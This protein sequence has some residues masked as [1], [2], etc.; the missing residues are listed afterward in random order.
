MII[1]DLTKTE[2]QAAIDAGR[3]TDTSS[4]RSFYCPPGAPHASF[5][6]FRFRRHG[7]AA[8]GRRG[9]FVGEPCQTGWS[10]GSGHGRTSTWTGVVTKSGC[11]APT[12]PCINLKIASV[13]PVAS[14]RRRPPNSPGVSCSNSAMMSCREWW[15][16]IAPLLIEAHDSGQ[17]RF[18][19]PAKALLRDAEATLPLS[20]LKERTPPC[21]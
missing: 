21:L 1:D 9:R 3:T 2:V 20:L 5:L 15:S 13:S 10:S 18:D 7:G 17:Y 12:G 4:L 14:P 6:P 11:P 8:G 19:E 16:L